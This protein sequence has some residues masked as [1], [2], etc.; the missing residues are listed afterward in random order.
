MKQLWNDLKATPGLLIAAIVVIIAILLYVYN[1]NNSAAQNQQGSGPTYELNTISVTPPPPASAPAPTSGPSPTGPAV[2][3]IPTTI[4]P[5][6][7]KDKASGAS[8]FTTAGGSIARTLP[9]GSPVT[10]VG[11]TTSVKGTDYYPLQGGG[12]VKENDLVGLG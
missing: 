4:R 10:I 6:T 8:V 9:W 12:W 1:K 11:L 5:K 2:G 3:P 7:S